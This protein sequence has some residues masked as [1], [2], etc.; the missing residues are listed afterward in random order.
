MYGWQYTVCVAIDSSGHNILYVPL[1]NKALIIDVSFWIY[2]T[3]F[4]S[5]FK[6]SIVRMRY[7]K[8]IENLAVILDISFSKYYL[9]TL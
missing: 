9:Q 5:V 3:I 6:L 8:P 2:Y 4:L 7:D 1:Q